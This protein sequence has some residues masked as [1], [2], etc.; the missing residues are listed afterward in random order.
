MVFRSRAIIS[1]RDGRIAIWLTPSLGGG[2]DQYLVTIDTGGWK[3]FLKFW[4]SDG[5]RIYFELSSNLYFVDRTSLKVTKL[6]GFERSCRDLCVSRDEKLVA[7]VDNRDGQSDI[8]VRPLGGGTPTRV[9]SDRAAESSLVWQPNGK[10][11]IYSAEQDG[12]YDLR[13]AYLDGSPPRQFMPSPSRET[14][15]DVSGGGS[16]CFYTTEEKSSLWG[17]NIDDSGEVEI[18]AGTGVL[19]WPQVSPSQPS[20]AFLSADER[21]K[22]VESSILVAPIKYEGHYD[23][24]ARDGFAVNWSPDG[25][26]LGF[27]RYRN[28]SFDIWGVSAFGN[29]ERQI[30]REGIRV[31]G[32]QGL[33]CDKLQ[34]VEFSWSTDGKRL[35]FCSDKDGAQ[36]IWT[37]GED[38]S[39][40][41]KVSNNSDAKTQLSC[42]LFSPV[43]DRIAF[44]SNEGKG[45]EERYRVFISDGLQS[46]PVYA[47]KWIMRLL[48]WSL[49]GRSLLV[50]QVEGKESYP[51]EA[52]AVDVIEIHPD[53][54]PVRIARLDSVYLPSIRLSPDGR[55]AA[56][57][58]EGKRNV[59]G[60]LTIPDGRLKSL[61]YP[62]EPRSYFSGVAWSMD[63]RTVFCTKQN[64]Q[65]VVYTVDGLK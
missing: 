6:P 31:G 59:I 34:A 21:D 7:Y 42:P 29:D 36:N 58:E 20:V 26:R 44:S 51:T 65:T 10:R 19:L 8:W 43:D 62:T 22:L 49:D 57:M 38:G 45:K 37:V 63:E 13:E 56:V 18:S 17:L 61:N 50:A 47:S 4:S 12:T 9:T 54:A 30:T 46:Q 1:N 39:G 27:V 11:I 33:P 14:V 15:L 2:S 3:P 5:E 41:G 52:L 25:S 32:Y 55:I 53:A 64:I 24:V 60:V 40:E 35:A 23:Q 28:G 48:G 16:V